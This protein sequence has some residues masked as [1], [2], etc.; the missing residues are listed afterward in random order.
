MYEEQTY[1]AI[2]ERMLNRVPDTIDKR[3]GSIIY[4]ALAPAAMELAMMYWELDNVLTEGFAD[5]ASREYLEKRCAERNITPYPATYA[6]VKGSFEPTTLELSTGARFNLGE[7]NYAITEKVS[8]GVYKLKCETAGTEPN[9]NLG[10]V[11]PIEYIEGL[12]YG[13]ITDILI[14][15]EDEEDTEDLRERYIKSFNDQS[16]GGNVAWYK[17]T[18]HA[19]DGVGGVKIL[20][21]WNGAGTVKCIIQNSNYGVPTA[22]LISDV[23]TLID[24]TQN[25]GD[26]VGLAPI[27]HVVTVEG[28]EADT[29]TITTSLTLESGITW[30]DIKTLAE[31]EIDSYLN[32]LNAT[33][34]DNENLIVRISQLETHLLNVTGV[35]DVTN[36]KI[37]GSASNHTVPSNQVAV[38]G[39]VTN[40]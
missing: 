33:W 11:T 10:E 7:Y 24:P 38:R 30:D 32:A 21:A 37:N 39:T 35:I 34:E 17:D 4:D 16:S 13:E 14:L 12:T 9:A 36:T 40:G 27:G 3:E 22:T 29:L 23:Q 19:I 15:G 25:Q 1:E 5:T 31:A 20:R 8:E 2:L 18:I 6:V 26:G 28:V